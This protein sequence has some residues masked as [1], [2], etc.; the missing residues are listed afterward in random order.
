MFFGKI[1]GSVFLAVVGDRF[2][3]RTL[4]ISGLVFCL[5]GT[6]AA[7]TRVSL[8]FVIFGLFTGSIGIDVCF[9]VTFPMLSEEVRQDYS[10]KYIVVVQLVYGFGVMANVLWTYIWR[11]WITTLLFFYAVPFALS[12]FC[13][14]MLTVDTPICLITKNSSDYALQSFKYISDLNKT[15]DFS[16]TKEEIEEIQAKYK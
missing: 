6:L 11:D 10:S 14:L 4:I 8:H 1:I 7:L 16:V 2:G 3:R 15:E 12:A 9:Y 5:F 13:M